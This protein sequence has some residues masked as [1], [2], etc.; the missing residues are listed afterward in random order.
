MSNE[1][2]QEKMRPLEKKH[3]SSKGSRT[4]RPSKAEVLRVQLSRAL[5]SE[6]AI[7]AHLSPNNAPAVSRLKIS[8]DQR[9]KCRK[10]L[11]RRVVGDHPSGRQDCCISVTFKRSRK[12]SRKFKDVCLASY[13]LFSIR[14]PRGCPWRSSSQT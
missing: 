6:G 11:T 4:W 3:P 7:R 8:N 12:W 14:S 5:P 9:D 10:R 1:K 13:P 2:E